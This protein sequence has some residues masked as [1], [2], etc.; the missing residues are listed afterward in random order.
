M[1]RLMSLV[2]FV[3]AAGCGGPVQTDPGETV[4][5]PP[6]IPI[7][8]DQDGFGALNGDCDDL[9][10]DVYPGAV[11]VCNGTDDNCDGR[12]DEELLT[13]FYED[14]DGDGFGDPNTEVLACEAPMGTVAD[15]SDCDDSDGDSYPGA[16]EVE[17][18]GIDQDCNGVDFNQ[19]AVG[20]RDEVPTAEYGTFSPNGCFGTFVT[21]PQRLLVTHLGF[22]GQ[23]QDPAVDQFHIGL[24][25]DVDGDPE[26]LLTSEEFVTAPAN[27]ANEYELGTPV[28][29]D[30]G[31]AWVVVCNENWYEGGHIDVETTIISQNLH[32]SGGFDNGIHPVLTFN[33][34]PAFPLTPL[35]WLLGT[36]SL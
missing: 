1:P 7:D 2:A 8:Q 9:N 27:G 26:N 36:P 16:P 13:Q 3:F 30:A 4:V 21:L 14:S 18:D 31:D 6:D 12:I 32:I 33:P 11:E 34:D 28:V 20:F 25:E 5:V 35:V 15:N 22:A 10:P 24:Y 23:A 17:S 29:V 19:I